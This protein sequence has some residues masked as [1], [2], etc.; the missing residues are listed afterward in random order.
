MTL[1]NALHAVRSR[2][3]LLVAGLLVGLGAG[4]A[5]SW[6]TVPVYTSSTRL[7]LGATGTAD[8]AG[9]YASSL[10]SE[11][12]AQSYVRVL[13]G[14]RLSRRVIDDVGLDLTP[15]ELA[16]TVT[17]RA[18][19]ETAILE[20][21]AADGSPER[22]QEIADSFGRHAIEELTALETTT[23]TVDPAVHVTTLDGA[24]FDP[25]PVSPDVARNLALGGLLGLLA[26][27]LGVLLPAR[28]GRA[29][30]SRA[31]IRDGTGRE[32]LGTL[33]DDPRLHRD[34]PLVDLHTDSPNREALRA[35]GRSL[36]HA[37]RDTRPRVVV[38]TST[39]RGE[40]SST[41]AVN[42]AATLARAG[43]RTLLIDADLRCPGV[44]RYLG[45][46]EG[47]GLTDVLSG[48]A[49]LEE[50]VR[51]WGEGTLTVLAAGSV[52]LDPSALHDSPALRT[53][54]GMLTDS[55]DVVI[56]DAPALAPAADAAVLAAEADGCIVVTR[57]G[58][59]RREQLADAVAVLAREQAEL[60]GV[61]LNRVPERTARSWRYRH[62]YPADPDRTA[63]GGTTGRRPGP[64]DPPH[65]AGR[66]TSSP[67][68]VPPGA[69]PERS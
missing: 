28:F 24:S 65:R 50:A 5:V 67:V 32:I 30:T 26:G 66:A 64:A 47:L 27:L 25:R 10:F 55:R 20:V 35:I 22:A 57:Y 18:V 59:T 39:V 68:T 17:V 41:V 15:S 1:T 45:L 19:P 2:W 7:F 33:V 46:T 42:L 40:G 6:T 62:L 38:V 16:A 56:I 23:G 34:V 29:V 11:Q 61:V 49:S 3:L 12:R 21:T 9:A 13:E 43:T 4:A 54:V 14:D 37:G 53:L 58:A 31:D 69:F 8:R 44:T 52:P 60:L 36:R 48:R 51:P 63:P